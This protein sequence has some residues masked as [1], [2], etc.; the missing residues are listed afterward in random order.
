[1][2]HNL[3]ENNV[4]TFK[5]LI[6]FLNRRLDV[7]L[8]YRHSD[9][10]S[11]LC[12]DFLFIRTSFHQLYRMKKEVRIVKSFSNRFVLIFEVQFR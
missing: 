10:I 6:T 3:E 11:D 5:L 2:F 12:N 4:I 9:D 1:M 7:A 8:K